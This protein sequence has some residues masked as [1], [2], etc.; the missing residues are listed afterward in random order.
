MLDTEVFAEAE[1]VLEEL[2]KVCAGTSPVAEVDPVLAGDIRRRVA[3][4]RVRVTL[5]MH[6]L[7]EKDQASTI[8]R[9]TNWFY[10]RRWLGPEGVA[11]GLTFHNELCRREGA[12]GEWMMIEENCSIQK[13]TSLAESLGYRRYRASY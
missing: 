2:G 3:D 12:C 9:K 8:H 5:A 6:R 13:A 11:L 1:E 10:Q 4:L 7:L